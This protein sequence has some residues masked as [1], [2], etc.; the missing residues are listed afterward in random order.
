MEMPELELEQDRRREE[1]MQN[2]ERGWPG[3]R[4]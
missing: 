3:W 2:Y 1:A 4:S